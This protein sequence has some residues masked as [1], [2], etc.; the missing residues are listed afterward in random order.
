MPSAARS[1]ALAARTMRRI[2][3]ASRR[4]AWHRCNACRRTCRAS[5]RAAKVRSAP[6]K[7]RLSPKP[8]PTRPI[9]LRPS[10][11]PSRPP[12]RR[13]RQRLPRLPR[14]T[15]QEAEQ[16]AGCRDPQRLSRRLPEELRQRPTRGRRF[17]EL[18]RAE[19]GEA[20]GKLPAGRQCSRRQR[21]ARRKRRRHGDSRRCRSRAGDHGA[22]ADASA[23]RIVRVALGLRRRCPRAL[24]R[25]TG[26]RGPHRALPGRPGRIA[27]TRVQGG[28]VVVCRAIID[29]RRRCVSP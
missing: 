28:P 22:A 19:Q 27:V 12:R 16:R 24:R 15:G 8:M 6:S 11:Q 26:R 10:L 1:A 23:R 25:D 18:S 9:P 21:G 5:P 14:H 13:R 20:L 29:Q 2:A 7:R 4:A 17:A 3:P